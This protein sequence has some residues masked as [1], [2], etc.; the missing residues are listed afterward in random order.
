[1]ASHV[2]FENFADSLDGGCI[3]DDRSAHIFSFLINF[4]TDGLHASLFTVIPN[5]FWKIEQHGTQTEHKWNPL[6]ILVMNLLMEP[7]V[8]LSDTR[9]NIPSLQIDVINHS[10][11]TS[12][13]I[14]FHPFMNA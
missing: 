13:I 11:I 10:R 2:V 1:M 9:M 8:V 4:F 12:S 6:V 3:V 5:E 14:E 7:L